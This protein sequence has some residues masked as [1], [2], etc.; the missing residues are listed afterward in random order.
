MITLKWK[1]LEEQ[2][3]KQQEEEI[4]RRNNVLFR[5]GG[6]DDTMITIETYK[7]IILVSS[8]MFYSNSPIL[9]AAIKTLDL[10]EWK[11]WEENK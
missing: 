2:R 3:R 8:D 4:N 10:P 6:K 9:V 1:W 7:G 5:L 11:E